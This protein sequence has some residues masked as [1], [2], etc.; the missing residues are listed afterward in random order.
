MSE[1]QWTEIVLCPLIDVTLQEI[2]EKAI[3]DFQE[4]YA[5]ACPRGRSWK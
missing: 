1:Q 5:N 4:K 2:V 3:D